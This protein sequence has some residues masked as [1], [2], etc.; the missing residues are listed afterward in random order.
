MDH[1]NKE[2]VDHSRDARTPTWKFVDISEN[3]N[4]STGRL[5]VGRV[6][7]DKQIKSSVVYNVL[8]QAYGDMLG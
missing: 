1:R 2:Y 6:L 3:V 8:Q 4:I 5:C 7:S